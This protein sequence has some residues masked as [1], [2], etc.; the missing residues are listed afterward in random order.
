MTH[1]EAIIHA[2]R[3]NGPC[4]DYA[5]YHYVRGTGLKASPSSIRTRR[6]E[7]ERD[8]YVAPASGYETTPSGRQAQLWG[9]AAA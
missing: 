1:R 8:G 7:L 2:L 3:M 4:S 5:L 9:L 6:H